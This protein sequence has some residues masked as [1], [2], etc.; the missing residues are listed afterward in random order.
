MQRPAV[1][2][3]V[4][5][6]NGGALV[7]RCVAHLEALEWPRDRL[8]L[9]VVDNAST[10]GSDRA[11]EER[12]PDVRVVRSTVNRG[13]PANN[14]AMADL[15]EV[16]YVGLVNND[17]FVEPD[18][19]VELVRELEEDPSVGAACP[20]ILLASQF[21]DLTITTTSWR[22]PGDGR[23]LG[24]R[25]SGIEVDGVDVMPRCGFPEGV[26]D[27]EHAR[28]AE[29]SFRWTG[30]HA[31]VRVPVQ[32]G[33]APPERVRVRLATAPPGR[34]ALLCVGGP[35]IKVDVGTEPTWIDV[36]VDAV[37]Y[38]VVNNVGSQLIEGGWGADRGF[39]ERDRGQF[40]EAQDV[41]AWCGAGVLLRAQHLREA[42]LFDER[43]FMYYEDTDLSWR[44][45][46][47]GWRVRYTPRAVMRHVHAA[48]SIEGSPMFQHYV[49]RNRLIMLMKNAPAAMVR[50][51]VVGFLRSTLSYARRDVLWPMARGRRP[52]PR[53]VIA[54]LRSFIAFV[55]LVPAL[56]RDRR[57]LRG[58]QVVPDR[59]IT[60]WA[61][62]R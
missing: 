13:F 11:V 9:V 17:A 60:G 6:F 30:P 32:P 54:R 34:A 14:L 29:P 50:S 61:V 25:I 26:Y 12:F 43:F 48:T 38:D 33:A 62:P 40:D 19:L 42:G 3:I 8:E 35:E 21:V 56:R 36:E 58:R 15:S 52:R 41:F 59:M 27:L 46:S 28:G 1:R 55:R 22:A 51:A 31:V 18:W 44:G 23:D 45:R 16:D 39:L 7:E 20:K 47:L 37:P 2:L 24:V 4:L 53:L 57:V 49:E 5:N 10:D